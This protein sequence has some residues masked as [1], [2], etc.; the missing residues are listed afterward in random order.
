MSSFESQPTPEH[1]VAKVQVPGMRGVSY[2]MLVDNPVLPGQESGALPRARV[3]TTE[4][5]K[6]LAVAR[7]A[8]GLALVFGI[9]VTPEELVPNVQFL[10]YDSRLFPEISGQNSQIGMTLAA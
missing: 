7:L 6:S 9:R 8:A 5:L 4:G 2:T 3:W 10:P 1:L